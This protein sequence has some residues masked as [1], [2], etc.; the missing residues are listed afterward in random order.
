MPVL[1]ERGVGKEGWG[2]GVGTAAPGCPLRAG[3]GAC[4]YTIP[5]FQR[6]IPSIE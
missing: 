3:E 5:T 1:Q 2:E 6:K 4:P